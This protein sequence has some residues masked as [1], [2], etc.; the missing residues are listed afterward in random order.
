MYSLLFCV[1]FSFSFGSSDVT[2][3]D[4]EKKDSWQESFD[5]NEKKG[6]YN[7][8]VSVSD[9]GGNITLA[10]PFNIYIDPKSDLPVTGITNPSMSQRVPGNLNILGTA[11][12]DDAVDYV[13]LI[14]DG[15]SEKPVRA[16]GKEFWSYFLDTTNLEEGDHKIEAYSVDINGLK[17]LT[18]SV[19]WC[20]DRRQPDTN[21]TNYGIGT[22]VSGKVEL[23]GTIFDG[24]GIASLDYMVNGSEFEKAPISYNKKENN[25]EF[26]FAIETKKLPD[27]PAVVWFRATDKQ[28]SVG[29]YSFLLFV[30]N[31]KPVVTIVSPED[32]EI[33]KG[34][35]AAAGAAK[36]VIGLKSL[37]WEFGGQKGDFE[38]VPGNQFWTHE[39]NFE[40]GVKSGKLI[41]TAEDTAGNITVSERQIIVDNEADKPV[42]TIIN[43]EAASE[44]EDKELFVRGIISDDDGVASV[45][46]SVD[47]GAETVI[48]TKGVFYM[49][50]TS[51]DTTLSPGKHKV[52]V[53]GV[54]KNGVVGNAVVN[55]FTVK[56]PKPSFSA[57][58]VAGGKASGNIDYGKTIHPEQGGSIEIDAT[59]A[60]GIT[61]ATCKVEWGNSGSQ[62]YPLTI[63]SAT[64][65]AHFSMPIDSLPW[66][67]VHL[68]YTAE[69]TYGRRSSYSS[70]VY[71]QNLSVV[72]TEANRNLTG[73]YSDETAKI[74]LSTV[75]GT[76]YKPGMVV[77]VPFGKA[78]SAVA[79]AETAAAPLQAVLNIETAAAVTQVSYKFFGVEGYTPIEGKA[80]LNH[81]DKTSPLYDAIIPLSNLPAGMNTLEITVAAGKDYT[82]SLTAQLAIVRPM[83]QSRVADERKVY[84]FTGNGSVL[85]ESKG[86]YLLSAGEDLLGYANAVGP[87]TVGPAGY[88]ALQTSAEGNVIRVHPTADGVYRGAAVRVTDATGARFSSDLANLIVSSAGPVVTL[89]TPTLYQWVRQTFYVSGTV[90]AATGLTAVDYST[91][92]GKTWQSAARPGSTYAQLAIS[93]PTASFADGL[94]NLDIRA[95]DTVGNISYARTAVQ[96]DT[97]APVVKVV[98]PG[99]EEKVNG[100]NVIA[101]I[102][103]DAGSLEKIEYVRRN[104][105][106]A[107][108]PNTSMVNTF[109]GTEDLPINSTMRFDF[110]DAAGNMTSL[111]SWDFIIDAASDLPVVNIQL[112]E[113]NQVITHDFVISGVV[114]DDD[115]PSKIMYRIDGRPFV[116]LPEA[117]YSFSIDVPLSSMTD[118]EHSVTVYAVDINGVRGN[119]VVRNF[120][121]SLEEPKNEMTAPEI[122]TTQK[123]IVT[124]RG[125]ASDRNGIATVEISVDN[126]NSYNMAVGT[127]SWSYTFDTRSIPDGTHVVFL[128][129]TDGYGIQSMYSS[130]INVDNTKPEISLE[131]PLD[132]SRTT[133]PVFFSGFTLDNI[134]LTSLYIRVNGL[135][136]RTVPASLARTDLTP[137]K[138]ITQT[139]N[140]NALASGRY[141]VELI[142]TDAAGNTTTVSRN[143]LLDKSSPAAKVDIYYPLNGEH[144]QGKFN[145]Y[146][147]VEADRPVQNVTLFV[148]GK[149]LATTELS[150][151]GYYKFAIDEGVL[152]EGSHNYRVQANLEGSVNINSI[153]QSVVYSPYGSWITIDNFTYGD[154]AI[155][156]PF[157]KGMAGYAISQEEIDAAKAKGATKLQKETLAAKSISKVELSMNN[158]KTF[159]KVST[160][161]K[162]QYR[163]ENED[164]QEGYYFL[165]LRVTMKNGETAITRCLVQIDKTAPFVRIISPGAG[166]R[167][168]QSLEFSGLASDT[169]GLNA[170]TLSLRKGDKAAY[171]VPAFI[172]G[173]YVDASVWGATLYSVG[174]G[175]TFFDDNVKLQAQWGQFTQEQRNTFKMSPMRYGG[176][177]IIGLKILANV[178][179]FP[180]RTWFGPDFDWLSMALAVGANF[181]YF[182]ESAS[183]KSQVLSAM[184]AQIE[185]PRMTFKKFKFAKNISLYTEFQWWFIPSDVT[186]G[187][188]DIKNMVFQ[189]SEGVR[190]SVF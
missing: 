62:E 26:K 171:E 12:D 140:L 47:G 176:D 15:D 132:D 97:T 124:L 82:A 106:R 166:G 160:G 2:E 128:K 109:V 185:L 28:G 87:V 39:F 83:D 151:T 119:Q 67:V 63:T 57:L 44:L 45:K 159:T 138:I 111:N 135:D 117:G 100:K 32:K 189:F 113:E 174:A 105:T 115:G 175:L 186:G 133:G 11:I 53:T 19:V 147:Y 42:A 70:V 8:I 173:L 121:V 21:V 10:G 190:I 84:W 101:F 144:K 96:K 170:V 72:K 123:E 150:N 114:L 129:T 163:I 182:N 55:E 177:S 74:A 60:V 136:G 17:G 134:G 30:D 89:T 108:I 56:A 24:N 184:I 153:Q 172:Q 104:A 145:I 122:S 118:N 148:D 102:A 156:R 98:V 142:G 162:W 188:V 130:L 154:F 107:E 86:G 50:L 65:K 93:V 76:T 94:I 6:K 33:V 37:T 85:D 5:I 81:A 141:N 158:G 178:G 18:S 169:V 13:E 131:L 179:R 79:T 103:N 73:N 41:I 22:L 48:A 38:L 35:F 152:T 1:S 137:E 71:V 80:T 180:F 52:S 116:E 161:A 75:A 54:D 155:E 58:T 149:N 16:K 9:L 168:N 31:T 92:G 164:M 4:V 49:P 59:S 99:L 66:G 183:G 146:G 157:L 126:A 95:V 78:S 14:L 64:Q 51:A 120:R 112:P 23:K 110:T 167:Y 165:L 20:L 90:T 139:I 77:A 43:P 27:G 88:A 143:V 187:S 91:D 36:D 34:V 61:K 29:F 46:I 3:R 127:T 25:T 40:G 68:V 181:S 7:V 69:D 125:T